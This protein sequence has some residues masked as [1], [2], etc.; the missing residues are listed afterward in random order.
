M[1][2]HKQHLNKRCRVCGR[3]ATTRQHD[4]KM[5]PCRAMLSR[6]YGIIVES[7]SD[8]IFPPFI[9]NSCYLVLRR[10]H[11]EGDT[12]PILNIHSWS[13]HGDACQVCSESGPGRQKKTV[14]RGRPS[15][16]NPQYISRNIVRKL[17]TIQTPQ[18]VEDVPLEKFLFLPFPFIDHLLC[19]ICHCIPNKPIEL[20]TC[21]H[22]LCAS[23]I[24]N[25]SKSGSLACPCS[26]TVNILP[27]QLC[28]PSEFVQK[29][30]GSLL[31]RCTQKCGQVVQLH[32]LKSHLQSKCTQT[33][34]PPPNTVTV[35]QLLLK[36]PERE[37]SLMVSHTMGLVAENMLASGD[38]LTVRSSKGKVSLH[39]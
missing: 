17:S 9:C 4:K 19:Q 11:I 30:M 31:V 23:C 33:E 27:D 39:S 14:S 37:P 15:D 35:E 18:F 12:G 29:M 7:E 21:R 26:S 5:D 2:Q 6:V 16:D 1:E 34:I 13:P 8:D 25:I 22:Y 32:H 20:L 3:K 38:H 10:A 24:G 36:D 28:A